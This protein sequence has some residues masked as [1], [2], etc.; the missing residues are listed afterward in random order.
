MNGEE[1]VQEELPEGDY[2]DEFYQTFYGYNPNTYQPDYSTYETYDD[3]EY[4]ETHSQ[5]TE[6]QENTDDNAADESAGEETEMTDGQ[7]SDTEETN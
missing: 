1:L 6:Y 4:E 5:E 2:S 7:Q 3:S